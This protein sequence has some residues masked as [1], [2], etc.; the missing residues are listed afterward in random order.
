M[1]RPPVEQEYLG[2]LLE[3]LPAARAV[4]LTGSAALG[5]YVP[6]RS[7]LDVMVIA[8]APVDAAGIAARCS[9]AALPCPARKLEL[10]VYTPE[11]VSEPSRDQRWELN[12]NTGAEEQHVGTDPDAEPWFWFVLDL[13]LAREHG[14]ALHGPP[15]A[16]VIG[17][18]PREVV[19]AAQADAVAWYAHN[20]PGEGALLAAARAWLYAEEGR[21]AGKREALQWA[22]R[23]R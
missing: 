16:E 8:D 21:F 6:G 15:P 9:H 20:E 4:Y 23:S 5:A 11:Q 2:A 7:D 17:P 1:G 19:L 12:L 14:V 22:C 18:A 10:V 13:A 3:R